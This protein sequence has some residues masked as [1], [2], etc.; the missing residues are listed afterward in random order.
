MKYVEDHYS[1]LLLKYPN[2]MVAVHVNRVIAHGT[3]RAKVR[4]TVKST[5][6]D[7]VAVHFEF[8]SPLR[9]IR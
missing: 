7:L 1:K 8:M 3:D 2:E 5:G 4:Q 6:V 9:N